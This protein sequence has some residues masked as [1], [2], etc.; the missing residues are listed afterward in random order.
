[1]GPRRLPWPPGALPWERQHPAASSNARPQKN[2]LTADKSLG[3]KEH[4][5]R[6]R[7]Q[8]EQI[9]WLHGCTDARALTG[10]GAVRGQ[11]LSLG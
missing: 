2:V 10:N 11:S 4:R 7:T 6:W 3:T 1:M 5:A 9:K 8:T